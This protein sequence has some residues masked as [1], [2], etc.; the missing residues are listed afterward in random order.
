MGGTKVMIEVAKIAH[1]V[2]P[3]GSRVTCNPPVLGTDEDFLVLLPINNV[4]RMERLLNEQG[5]LV[6][7]SVFVGDTTIMEG[8]KSYKLGDLNIIVTASQE[9]HDKFMLATHVATK[10]NLLSKADRIDLFVA[11]LYGKVNDE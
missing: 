4:I 3:V 6:G 5:W 11:I 1:S 8:F 10:L 9:W 7:G 2:T